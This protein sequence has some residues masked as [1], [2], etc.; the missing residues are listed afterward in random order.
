MRTHDA[1]IHGFSGRYEAFGT[2]HAGVIISEQ[3][4][5]RSGLLQWPAEQW[6]CIRSVQLDDD[7]TCIYLLAGAAALPDCRGWLKVLPGPT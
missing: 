4:H 5:A 7:A 6:S 2:R 1:A 3:H